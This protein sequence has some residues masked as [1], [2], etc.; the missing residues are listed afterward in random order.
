MP[1]VRPAPETPVGH[2]ALDEALDEALLDPSL[3]PPL[4]GLQ[5]TS[6]GHKPLGKVSDLDD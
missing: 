1:K 4:P 3:P 6:R 2:A 5:H